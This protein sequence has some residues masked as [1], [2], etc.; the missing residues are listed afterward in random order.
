MSLLEGDLSHVSL[1]GDLELLRDTA[2]AALSRGASLDALYEALATQHPFALMDMVMG[3]KALAGDEAVR[4]AL[5]VLDALESATRP[6]P[7]YRRLVELGAPDEVLAMAVTRHP[8]GHWLESVAQRLKDGPCRL[9]ALLVVAD[10]ETAAL[11][12]AAHTLD[13]QADAPLVPWLAAAS[14]LA[15]EPFFEKLIPRL[16]SKKAARALQ[17]QLHPFPGVQALLTLVLPGMI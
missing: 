5:R 1:P 14:G 4:A 3:P 7:L 2:S 8:A 6:G 13:Q 12:L 10:H 16:R 17:A 15:C 9:V 11:D